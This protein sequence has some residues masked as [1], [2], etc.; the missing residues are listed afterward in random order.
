MDPKIEEGS[1]GFVDGTL[2]GIECERETNGKKLLLHFG[3][4]LTK[5]TAKWHMPFSVFCPWIPSKRDVDP[6]I[7]GGGGG[8]FGFPLRMGMS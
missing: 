1:V 2:F 4:P 3:G 7:C 6:K 8:A 5:D